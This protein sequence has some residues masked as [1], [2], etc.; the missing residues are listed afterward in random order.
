[1]YRYQIHKEIEKLYEQMKNGIENFPLQR[2]RKVIA[3]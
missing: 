1:M 2:E 3:D